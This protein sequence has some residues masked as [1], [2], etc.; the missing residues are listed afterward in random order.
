MTWAML[1]MNFWYAVLSVV[2]HEDF[3]R[4]WIT[5]PRIE[6]HGMTSSTA[7]VSLDMPSAGSL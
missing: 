5:R 2:R 6:V 1:S 7:L 4:P 3:G